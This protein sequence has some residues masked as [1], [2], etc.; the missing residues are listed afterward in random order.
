MDQDLL[1]NA[2]VVELLYQWVHVVETTQE[3]RQSVR[4]FIWA[5]EDC[6]GSKGTVIQEMATWPHHIDRFEH[7]YYKYLTKNHIFV[8]NLLYCIQKNIQVLLHYYNMTSLDN[9]ETVT[10]SEFGELQH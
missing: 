6:L 3:L 4:N 10:L 7:Q 5:M 1:Y 8:Y 2:K 9:V